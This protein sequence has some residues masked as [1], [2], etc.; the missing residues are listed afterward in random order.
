MEGTERP[1]LGTGGLVARP[2]LE[3]DWL[4]KQSPNPG[5]IPFF[6][7]EWREGGG[8]GGLPGLVL[9]H[10]L[11]SLGPFPSGLCP[12]SGVMETRQPPRRRLCLKKGK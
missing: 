8:A 1:L 9:L 6:G 4:A 12:L 7:R 3:P 5:V 2:L 10:L 11:A